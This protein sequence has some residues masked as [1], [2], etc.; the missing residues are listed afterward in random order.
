MSKSLQS[1]GLQPIR[2]LCPWDCPPYTPTLE[3]IKE[4][5]VLKWGDAVIHTTGLV[6]MKRLDIIKHW[7]EYQVLNNRNS[8]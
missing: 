4:I 7:Q 3:I 1:H 5:Q 2:L 8:D 6:K